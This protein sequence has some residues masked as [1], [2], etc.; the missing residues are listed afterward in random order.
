MGLKIKIIVG[1]FAVLTLL[2]GNLATAADDLRL[3]NAVKSKD[4]AAVRS[5]LNEKVGKT[6][7]SASER[8]T[9]LSLSKTTR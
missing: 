6:F 3:V 8:K 9:Y 7:L 5:L 4:Q 2:T 1:W